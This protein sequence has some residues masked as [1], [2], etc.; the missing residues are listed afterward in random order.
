MSGICMGHRLRKKGIHSFR[1]FEKAKKMGGTWRDNV[2]P[3]IA[4]D[5]PAHLYS[6]SFELNPDWSYL[7]ARGDEIQKYIERCVEKF[8]LTEHFRGGSK[9][10]NASFEGDRWSVELENGITYQADFVVSAMGGLHIPSIPKFH[11]LENYQ[12]KFFHS[13]TW[14]NTVSLK[15]KKVAV[16]GT[17]ASGVQI[18]PELVD[19]VS[20]LTVFQRTPGWVLPRNDFHIS[21]Q[22]QK[23]F[24]K[25]PIL[26]RFYRWY[27]YCL[28]EWRLKFFVTGSHLNRWF[29]GVG[30]RYL[31]KC[32]PDEVLRK[33]LTPNYPIGCKRILYSDDYFQALQ[34]PNVSLVDEAVVSF[35]PNGIKSV[36][37]EEHEFDVVVAATGFKP[38]AI[39]EDIEIYGR[40]GLELTENWRERIGSHRTMMTHGFP[41]LFFLL[42]PNS[43]LGH[44]SIIL[45]IEAQVAFIVRLM[46]EMERNHST[47]VEPHPQAEKMFN[48]LVAKDLKKIVF[49][50]GCNSWYT[51]DADHNYT[52]WPHSTIRYYF[53]LKRL[54]KEEYI[55][56]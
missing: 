50:G 2:Y 21:D 28:I 1:I 40:K 51:D 43:G 25:F 22:W 49:S 29:N 27:I 16:I 32:V 7:Y 10:V 5:V 30:Y 19:K 13:A 53:E 31:R 55:W 3:G 11:G 42:G 15:G 34:K 8:Q 41:N 23:R 52:L 6:Y 20:Q 17:G 9:V 39:H 33:K 24:R 48:E 12:G 45:M 18:I 4:C 38:F 14:D 36:S 47:L 56:R 44:N 35:T 26:M 37:G 46:K 54:L